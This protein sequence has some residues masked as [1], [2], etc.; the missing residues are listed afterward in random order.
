MEVVLVRALKVGG[1][2]MVSIRRRVLAGAASLALAGTVGMV[3]AAP[4]QAVPGGGNV[5]CSSLDARYVELK[6]DDAPRAGQVITDG[7][8][9]VTITSVKTKAE[10]EV[11]AFSFE[12]NIPVSAV[13]VKASTKTKIYGVPAGGQA[14]T[15]FTNL[16]A[17]TKPDGKHHGISWVAFCYIP[18]ATS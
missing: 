4:A 6:L 10:G 14:R 9:R 11:V 15:V 12:A 8:L 17:P 1:S 7:T 2:R 3:A 13:I 16:F 18:P 5:S